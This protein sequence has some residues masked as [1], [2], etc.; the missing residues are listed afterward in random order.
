MSSSSEDRETQGCDPNA[1]SAP[2]WR[3]S[4]VGNASMNAQDSNAVA[5]SVRLDAARKTAFSAAFV[6]QRLHDSAPAFKISPDAFWDS[7]LA[8]ALLY[9]TLEL[10][11]AAPL[12]HP[13][14]QNL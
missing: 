13:R 14:D 12:V 6:I 9:S 4:P 3:G 1:D 7:A 2:R 10:F 5:F 8:V 11:P